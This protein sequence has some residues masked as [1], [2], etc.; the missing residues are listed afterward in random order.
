MNTMKEIVLI[1]RNSKYR[2]HIHY[3]S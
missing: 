1:N 3:G 2:N